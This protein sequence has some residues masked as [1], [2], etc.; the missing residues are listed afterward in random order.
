MN[1]VPDVMLRKMLEVLPIDSP[2]F[3]KK[4]KL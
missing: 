4:I 2:G 1:F 3:K